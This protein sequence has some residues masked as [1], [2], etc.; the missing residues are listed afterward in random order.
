MYQIVKE[1]LY[2]VTL[3]ENMQD[4]SRSLGVF[5]GMKEAQLDELSSSMEGSG[6]SHVNTFVNPEI[7]ARSMSR[8]IYK[9]IPCSGAGL[10]N[11]F[12]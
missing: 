2:I 11:F 4:L 6:V 5:T 12:V 10:E 7:Q 1:G 3:N 9:D 8:I